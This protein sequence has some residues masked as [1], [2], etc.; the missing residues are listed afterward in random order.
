MQCH[1]MAGL[2]ASWPMCRDTELRSAVLMSMIKTP[3]EPACRG[4]SP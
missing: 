3:Q 4:M 1:S 2:P